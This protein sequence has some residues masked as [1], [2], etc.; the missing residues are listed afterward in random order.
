VTVARSVPVGGADVAGMV[1]L[2]GT[3]RP[4]QMVLSTLEPAESVS[5][6]VSPP[7]ESAVCCDVTRSD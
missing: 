7:L 1:A 4:G 2:I 3:S 6:V 5:N